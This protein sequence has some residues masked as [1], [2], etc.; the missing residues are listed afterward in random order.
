[1]DSCKQSLRI[2]HTDIASNI[3]EHSSAIAVFDAETETGFALAQAVILN[4][5]TAKNKTDNVDF[6]IVFLFPKVFY[7]SYKNKTPFS[8]AISYSLNKG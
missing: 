5:I 8:I 7:S 4:K 2:S 3:F 6:L 1:M